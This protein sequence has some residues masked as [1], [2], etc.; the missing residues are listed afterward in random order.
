MSR[1][2][3]GANRSLPIEV[4]PTIEKSGIQVIFTLLED[5]NSG[6]ITKTTNTIWMFES[7]L[8]NLLT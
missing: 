7:V 3:S 6:P 8:P 2:M 1:E 5:Q 4:I